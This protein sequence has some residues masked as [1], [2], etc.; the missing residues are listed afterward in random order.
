MTTRVF[1]VAGT[2]TGVGKT[3]VA[4]ALLEAARHRGLRTAALKP[5]AAGGEHAGDAV[6]NADV[7]LLQ[8]YATESLPYDAANG[9]TLPDA[10][11]PHIAA[12]RV[13]QKLAAAPL[14]AACRRSIAPGAELVLIEGAGGWRVPLNERES[15]AEIPRL[16]KIPVILVVG[17]RLGCLNHALL[18][19]EAIRHDGLSLAG[20]AA[21]CL[22][23]EMEALQE[24]LAALQERLPAPCLGIIPYLKAPQ[25][26]QGAPHLHLERLIGP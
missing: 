23:C 5:V 10:L 21:S 7:L 20:W 1:F 2:D 19:A 25:P 15:M 26:S 16:L 18:S 6:H 22:T 12:R 4:C 14:A 11:A 13:G 24:N 8:R 9:V 17:M 3:L